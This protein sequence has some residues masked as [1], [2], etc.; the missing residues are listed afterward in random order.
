LPSR[1]SAWRWLVAKEWR[2]LVASRAWWIM[3]ALV[4]PLVGLS[5][6][7]AVRVYA[8]ASGLGGTSAGVG[9]AFS[10][11]VG[12]WAPTF[13][14]YELVSAFLLPFVVIRLVGGDRLSGALKIELQRPMWPISRVGAKAAVLAA[15]CLL[16][17]A[18]GIAAVALW[19]SYGGAAYAPEIAAVV[20]GHVLNAGLTI[21]L[22]AAAATLAEN[23]STAAILTLAV[24]IGTWILNFVAE[25]NGGWWERLAGFTPPAMVAEFQHGLVRLNVIVIALALSATGLG[26]AAI[27]LRLGIAVRRRIFESFVL[28]AVAANVIL[29]AAFIRVSWDLS[30]SRQNS[31]SEA[32]ERALRGIQAPLRMEVHLAPAD[33][34]RVDL[35]HETLSKLRRTLRAL[36]VDFVS[37]TSIGLFEQTS[38]HYGE[39]WYEL[40]GRKVMS[41]TTTT[42]GSLEAIYALAGLTAPAETEDVF[43]G[44]PL[45]ALPRGAAVIFYGVWPGVVLGTAWLVQ[46]R[47]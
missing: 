19:K 36:Q 32:D 18:A 23:P 28:G 1:R 6:I 42:E 39:I 10:P 16:S 2:E 25:V 27:W 7:S 34:R 30:E 41:R 9:E 29:A 12:I 8:E 3:L 5:F 17:S 14:A 46:R 44:H 31:F 37:A 35:E 4:G 15:G 11:L 40:N 24:T 20:T 26:I 13:S 45:A 21:G 43:R 38:D 47:H 33:P 22:A